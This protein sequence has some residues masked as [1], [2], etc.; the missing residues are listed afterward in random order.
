MLLDQKDEQ[1]ATERCQQG[2]RDAFRTVVEAYGDLLFGTAYLMTEDRQL[3][4]DMVQEAFLSAWKGI[5]SFR[6]GSPV[7]P[8]LL[9]ILVNSVLSHRR[10]RALLTLPWPKREPAPAFE[11]LGPSPEVLAEGRQEQ[12][13]VRRGM[14]RLSEGHRQVVILRYYA[15]LSVPDI[16]RVTGW[17]QGTV[18]SRLHR[19][20]GQ[21]RDMLSSPEAEQKEL[22]RPWTAD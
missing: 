6:P 17:R 2:D 21:L 14:A 15:E 9:R 3:A 5:G 18:K 4:E 13:E 20:L 22:L 7:R 10:R 19:A 1:N 16:A 12:E 8:W 11:T